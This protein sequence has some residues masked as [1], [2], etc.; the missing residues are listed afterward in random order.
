MNSSTVPFRVPVMDALRGAAIVSVLFY[1]FGWFPYGHLGVDL[2]FVISGFLVSRVF[3]DAICAGTKFSLRE[4]FLRRASKILPSYYFF[5]LVGTV[6]GL[7]YFAQFDPIQPF[8]WSQ[9]P[10]QIFFYSNYRGTEFWIYAH[11]WSVCVEEHFYCLLP[12]AL[13]IVRSEIRDSRVVLVTAVW[14]ILAGWSLRELSFLIGFEGSAATHNHL[15]TFA[16]GIILSYCYRADYFTAMKAMPRWGL[17]VLGLLVVGLSVILDASGRY[18]H[19]S[20]VC[21]HSL[22]ALGFTLLA[23]SLIGM[24]AGCPRVLSFFAVYSY[25]L[26]LWHPMLA[27]PIQRFW[28]TGFVPGLAY[29]SLSTGVAVVVTRLL[30]RPCL[31]WMRRKRKAGLLKISLAA[32]RVT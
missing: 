15:D 25:N 19:F 9:W 30:E 18:P 28:G 22:A 32:D 16:Y 2:F 1:H 27:K 13:L 29:V 12:V 4:F 5:L 26:Y 11:L 3:I 7:K 23:A 21:F 20:L 31:E 24:G 6:V 14:F 17:F 10:S 8:S